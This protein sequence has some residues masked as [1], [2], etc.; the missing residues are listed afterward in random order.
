M[1]V[2]FTHADAIA[3]QSTQV[4]RR[5]WIDTEYAYF[6]ATRYPMVDEAIYQCAFT[7]TRRT[8]NADNGCSRCWQCFQKFSCAGHIIF[9][10][11]YTTGHRFVLALLQLRQ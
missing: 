7:S 1:I 8:G 3:Q 2:P 4:K 11:R 10:Q 6:F 5:R 9:Y